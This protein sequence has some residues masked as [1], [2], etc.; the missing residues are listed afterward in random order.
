MKEVIKSV[1]YTL[2][3]AE[4]RLQYGINFGGSLCVRIYDIMDILKIEMA[5][6]KNYCA[7][8]LSKKALMYCYK[9]AGEAIK[10]HTSSR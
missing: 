3:G 9:M 6:Q 1:G 7:I 5:I 10:L 2:N 4:H 8:S